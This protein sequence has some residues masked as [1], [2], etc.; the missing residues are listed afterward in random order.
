[1]FII[2]TGK[3]GSGKSYKAVS[4][5]FKKWNKEYFILHSIDGVKKE[6]F[7]EPGCLEDWQEKYINS[8]ETSIQEFFTEA[9]QTELARNIKEE[10]GKRMMLIVDEAHRIFQDPNKDWL[11]WL[12][13]HRHIGQ[14]VVFITQNIMMI[15]HTYRKLMDYEMRAKISIGPLIL[16]NKI[17]N[18]ESCGMT[19]NMK[20]K[21]IF[22]LYKSY[23]IEG[24][25]YSNYIY[26][27]IAV[28]VLVGGFY[29]FKNPIK[30]EASKKPRQPGRKEVIEDRGIEYREQAVQGNMKER[31]RLFDDEISFVGFM[32]IYRN[33]KVLNAKDSKIL[34]K[35]KDYQGIYELRNIRPNYMYMSHNKDVVNVLDKR[36][37]NIVMIL[38]SNKPEDEE[39]KKW[40]RRD[41]DL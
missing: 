13:Y 35:V 15:H 20:K 14:T 27:F 10:S 31:R 41:D 17:E 22:K 36:T 6:Y 8:E 18:G 37:G 24:K 29:Y 26:A 33:Q 30:S 38:K 23:E 39:P 9:Y 28:L 34:V 32:G 16:Y 12:S 25:S 5:I 2:Y 40:R 3:P 19:L 11:A 21:K 7:N 4:D 1:M